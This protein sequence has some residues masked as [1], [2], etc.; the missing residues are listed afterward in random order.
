[1]SSIDAI[2]T[3]VTCERSEGGGHTSHHT[4]RSLSPGGSGDRLLSTG[5]VN[6]A[7][8]GGAT[9]WSE[10]WSCRWLRVAKDGVSKWGMRGVREECETRRFWRG[11]RGGRG[12]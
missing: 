11:E 5:H 6:T 10:G 4:P 12:G 7:V 9:H 3:D 2:I 1:M 8:A